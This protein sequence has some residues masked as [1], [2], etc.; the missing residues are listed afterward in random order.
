MTGRPDGPR[1]SAIARI[2]ASVKEPAT[3][4]RA[5]EDRRPDRPD[6]RLEVEDGRFRES[7]RGDR[8]PVER[9]RHL[10]GVEFGT[11]VRQEAMGIE[12][13]EADAGRGAVVVA[14]RVIAGHRGLKETGDPDAGPTGPEHHDPLIPEAA[15]DT[16]E[17]GEDPGQ[18]HGRGPLDVVVEAADPVPV[19]VEEPDRVVL[20]EVLPL[21]ERPWEHLGHGRDERLDECVVGRTTESGHAPARVERIGQELRPV[22]PDVER[23]GQGERRMDAGSG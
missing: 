15:A 19:S 17:R 12:E 8:V 22:R 18:R 2:A 6:H 13:R 16:A 23:D 1:P 14:Q 9:E 4:A 11:V 7:E 20:L 5:D 3:P 21:D 10:V